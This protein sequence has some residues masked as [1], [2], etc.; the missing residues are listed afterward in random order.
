MLPSRIKYIS[1][2]AALRWHKTRAEMFE[3]SSVMAA[4]STKVTDLIGGQR[5]EAG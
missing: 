4:K 2:Q 3:A 1:M 5:D